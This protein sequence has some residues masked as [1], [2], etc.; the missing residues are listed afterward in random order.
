VTT[1]SAR[2]T[3][4]P[5]TPELR[6]QRQAR[7]LSLAEVARRVPLDLGHL[8]RV[9]RGEASLSVGSLLRLA[10]VLGLNEVTEALEPYVRRSA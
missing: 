10:E 2:R 9:E 4:A 6:A 8:S 5:G 3:L 7:G 1:Q